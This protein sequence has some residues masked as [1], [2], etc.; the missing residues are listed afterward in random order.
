MALGEGSPPNTAVM[1]AVSTRRKTPPRE[2]SRLPGRKGHHRTRAPGR[3]GH[4]PRGTRDGGQGVT[5][6]LPGVVGWKRTGCPQVQTPSMR[7]TPLPPASP[8]RD[9]IAFPSQE[10]PCSQHPHRDHKIPRSNR[11]H[12]PSPVQRSH[13]RYQGVSVTMEEGTGKWRATP[14]WTHQITDHV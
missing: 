14:V 5:V 11:P 7:H 6:G 1:A 2:S 8:G 4:R 12:P 9:G 13:D 10:P 3:A